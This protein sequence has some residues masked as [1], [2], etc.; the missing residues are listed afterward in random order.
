MAKAGCGNSY[1][2]ESADDL[3]EPFQREFDL[4]TSLFAKQVF[5]HIQPR[6]GIEATVMNPY[7]NKDGAFILPDIAYGGVVWAVVHLKIPAG[8][9]GPGN[10]DK[11]SLFDIMVNP[12]DIHGQPLDLSSLAWNFPVCLPKHGTASVKN[13]LHIRHG[14]AN[15]GDFRPMIN[16]GM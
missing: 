7:L 12:N 6:S 9:T 11:Q 15:R 3:L 10:C 14:K 4:L 13:N 1:Y 8:L 2:G 16:I 5:L